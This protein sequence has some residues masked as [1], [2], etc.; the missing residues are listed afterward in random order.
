M[1]G[2]INDCV[3]CGLP[4]RLDGCEHEDWIC[5]V[6]G[7]EAEYTIDGIDMCDACAKEYLMGKLKDCISDYGAENLLFDAFDECLSV[8]DKC[9]LVEA[10]LEEG[11]DE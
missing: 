4:C 6:C 8:A 9:W 5:D 10:K 7:A 11:G 2:T 1:K 3:G